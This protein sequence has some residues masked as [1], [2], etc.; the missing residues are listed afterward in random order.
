MCAAKTRLPCWA[1]RSSRARFPGSTRLAALDRADAGGHPTAT[2]AI[3]R[4][5]AI[6][7]ALLAAA[8]LANHD[9]QVRTALEA[10]RAEQTRKVLES[11]D[12]RPS[13]PDHDQS[14]S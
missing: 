14:E 1:C 12:P 11:P 2:L 3:G 10:Y 5:G 9:P 4:A 7:A 8:M 6:N 13:T